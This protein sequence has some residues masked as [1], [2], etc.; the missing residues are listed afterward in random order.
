MFSFSYKFQEIGENV[1]SIETLLDDELS[2]NY[3]F[4]FRFLCYF[5]VLE[6]IALLYVLYSQDKKHF[7]QTTQCNIL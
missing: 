4:F 1:I 2:L 3:W 7:Y 6:E 5:S